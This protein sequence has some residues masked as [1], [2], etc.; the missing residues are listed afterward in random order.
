LIQR[1]K[2]RLASVVSNAKL[3]L[4]AAKLFSRATMTRPACIAALSG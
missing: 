2:L 3:A 1:A 4:F